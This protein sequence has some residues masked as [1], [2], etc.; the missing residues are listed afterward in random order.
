M[1]SRMYTF[2]KLIMK[3]FDETIV[4]VTEALKHEGFGVLSDI[5]IQMTLK[6]KINEDLPKYRILGACH[7]QLAFKAITLEP[8]IGT[9]LPCNVIVREI[10]TDKTEVSIVD[11]IASM[12]SVKNDL[13]GEVATEVQEKLIKVHQIL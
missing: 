12:T 7:P 6:K 3:N 2:D 13:L 9:M 5:D 11:P 8:K 10:S 1:E 4:L